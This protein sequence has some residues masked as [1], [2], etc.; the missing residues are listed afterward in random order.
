[1]AGN[2]SEW[3][4]DTFRPYPG[5]TASP[6]QF[7]GHVAVAS[8]PLDEEMK[9]VDLVPVEGSYK[10]LRG[11]SWKSDPFSTSSYHRNY[12]WPHYASDFFGFRTAADLET[13][14]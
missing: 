12:S 9:V 1:M 2:V 7:Q 3:V 6:E 8:T 11:G 5:S 10:V 14:Q 13:E 4:S